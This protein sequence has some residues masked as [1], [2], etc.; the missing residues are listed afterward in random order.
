MCSVCR[1]G[2]RSSMSEYSPV[3]RMRIGLRT[4]QLLGLDV[5]V[6]IPA[7]AGWRHF[8]WQCRRHQGADRD[9]GGECAGVAR[10]G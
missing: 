4:K 5:D 3:L 2:T 10:G 1:Y 7:A 8:E 6:L 9:R